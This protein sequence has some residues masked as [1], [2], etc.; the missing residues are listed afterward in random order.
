MM[1]TRVRGDTPLWERIERRDCVD[2]K[3]NEA[4][5]SG[6]GSVFDGGVLW[7]R[8]GPKPGGGGPLLLRILP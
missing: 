3:E 7:M 4:A 5:G 1:G 6:P 8:P 2:E